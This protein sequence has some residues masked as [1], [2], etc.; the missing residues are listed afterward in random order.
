M[1]RGRTPV[2]GAGKTVRPT[3]GGALATLAAT[4]PQ[5]IL[6]RVLTYGRSIGKDLR[7]GVEPASSAVIARVLPRVVEG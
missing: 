5:L 7:Y 1:G 3:F 6:D 4:D 2:P